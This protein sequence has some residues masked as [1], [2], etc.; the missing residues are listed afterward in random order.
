M[1][2][3]EKYLDY[4]KARGTYE[5]LENCITLLTGLSKEAEA[6]SI[7]LWNE[8]LNAEDED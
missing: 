6:K 4:V 5:D 8:F 2:N 1:K 7:I 3:T